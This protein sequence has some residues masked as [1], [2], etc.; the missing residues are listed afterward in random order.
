MVERLQE[1]TDTLQDMTLPGAVFVDLDGT[2][3]KGN[4]MKIFMK[5]LPSVLLSRRAPGAAVAALWWMALRAAR[6]SSH[7]SMKWRLTRIARRHF[8]DADW[9]EIAERMLSRL[10]PEVE[11]Y[12]NAPS[13]AQCARYIAT[14]AIAEY[15]IPLARLLG[16]D[17][18]IATPFT[19]CRSD[20]AETRGA[21]KRDAIR[22]LI[23]E[24]R[25]RLESFL[26][27]HTDD[28]ATAV[29][30]PRLTILVSDSKKTHR[31]FARVGAMRYL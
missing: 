5:R 27:D 17:G 16:Y 28:L 22:S 4:S 6:L 10:N 26:T 23:D 9:E 21:A 12:V 3:L 30:F 1:M 11:E 13:R 2:L 20:Y 31:R 29:A 25:L 8:E 7:R 18:A 19:E 15:A 14:A 24:K